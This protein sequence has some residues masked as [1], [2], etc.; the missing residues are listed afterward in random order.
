MNV[1]LKGNILRIELPMRDPK[2]SGSGK[3]VILASTG[4]QIDTGIEY[5]GQDIILNAN[6]YIRNSET[7]K[8]KGKHSRRKQEKS[9]DWTPDE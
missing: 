7:A 3:T 1:R 8:S 2:I 5:K 4:G 9:E 6:A